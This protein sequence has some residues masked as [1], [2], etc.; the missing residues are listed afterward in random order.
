MVNK[1]IVLGKEFEIPDMPEEDVKANLL[2]ILKE[3][4]P[5]IADELKKTKYSVR[6]EGNVLVVYRLSAIFG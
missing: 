6:V 4:D 2:S 5:E 1:L 3:L